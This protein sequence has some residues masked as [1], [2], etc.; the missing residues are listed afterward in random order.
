MIDD[1]TVSK[2]FDA[3]NI[4]DVVSDFVALKKRG[5]NYFG[6]CP[7]HNEKTA[8]F[9]VSPAK[10]IYYCFGC[11]KGGNSVNFIMEHENLPYY[12]ALK[13][14]ANK[15]HI[16]VTETE[17]TPEEQERHDDRESMMV[18]NEFA[19]NYFIRNMTETDEGR[20]IGYKYFKERGFNEETI[21]TFELGYSLSDRKA[22]TEF[23]LKSGYQ[24]KYLVSTS[25]GQT[26]SGTGLTIKHDDGYTFDRF[27]G[28][29][30]FP[31]H[32]ITGK[33]IGFGGRV[34][35]ART[36]GVNVKYMNSPQSEIYDKSRSLYGI[37]QA[38]ASIVKNDK[39][40][41]VEGYTDVLSMHQSGIENVVASNGTALTIEQIRLIKKFTSNVTV[42]YDGDDAGI[43][44]ALR[45]IDMILAEGLN[46]KVL[47]LPD[48]EDPDSFARNHSSSEL[49][50]FIGVNETDFVLFKTRL[51]LND[52]G[53]DPIKK[54]ELINDI[55]ASIAVVPDDI[56]RLLYVKECAKLMDIDEAV[57]KD[58]TE[59]KLNKIT[60]Q[61]LEAA[62]KERERER[63]QKELAAQTQTQAQ[64]QQTQIQR[65]ILN[66]E[67]AL[68]KRVCELES[69]LLKYLIRFGNN[70]LF[71]VKKE[72]VPTEIVTVS[73]YILNELKINEIVFKNEDCKKMLDI[74]ISAAEQS[75]TPDDSLFTQCHDT[76]VS[77]FAVNLLVAKNEVSK[78]FW[79]KRNRYVPPEQGHLKDMVDSTLNHYK[80]EIAQQ[81]IKNIGKI[82]AQLQTEPDNDEKIAEQLSKLSVFQ[83]YI[84]KLGDSLGI[85]MPRK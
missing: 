5:N 27:S 70:V 81:E 57:L 37:Y 58:A 16:E 18:L 22:F 25:N 39:C 13:Y 28:R 79:D 55:V 47:L 71:E 42:L 11:H 52:A 19:K 48:G 40:F 53:N 41:L 34:L 2:I 3:A 23:A 73:Q 1:A 4:L 7:F 33:V 9:S 68:N 80:F 54:A 85:V 32:N 63:R 75:H 49:E 67:T 78:E 82:I 65:P 38:K 8:S 15:F 51:L 20:A 45:G 35:D 69:E 46:V 29:V 43:H 44:A 30:M 60:Y 24:L 17:R 66:E 6:C 72:S 61:Q 59:K 26:N 76:N 77:S 31:I 64:P 12:E 84:I 56:K 62:Q 14:L 36:K 50:E 10:N 74:Y 21:K 83:R